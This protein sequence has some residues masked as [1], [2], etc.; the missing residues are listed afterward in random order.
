MPVPLGKAGLKPMGAGR[1]PPSCYPPAAVTLK[2]T[3][4]SRPAGCGVPVTWEPGGRRCRGANYAQ[5]TLN[6]DPVSCPKGPL[7]TPG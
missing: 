2:G 3:A 6:T 4:A 5:G 7:G 1:V